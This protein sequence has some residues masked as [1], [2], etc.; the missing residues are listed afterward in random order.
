MAKGRESVS[1]Y[2]HR[3]AKTKKDKETWEA[4]KKWIRHELEEAFIKIE[5]EKIASLKGPSKVEQQGYQR[6]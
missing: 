3:W 4:E 6:G 1:K 2:K 5:S